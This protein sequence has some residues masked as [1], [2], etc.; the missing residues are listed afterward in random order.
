MSLVLNTASYNAP[1]SVNHLHL[2]PFKDW[3]SLNN[4]VSFLKTSIT[5]ELGNLDFTKS[6]G[7]K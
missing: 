2:I 1:L 6:P 4:A 5:G 3:L 7:L